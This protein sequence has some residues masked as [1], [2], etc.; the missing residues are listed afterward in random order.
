M[1][2][3][4]CAAL[5][6]WRRACRPR[7]RQ[8]LPRAAP[9]RGPRACTARRR[10]RRVRAVCEGGGAARGPARGGGGAPAARPPARALCAA[11]RS[12]AQRSAATPCLPRHTCTAPRLR[13]VQWRRA[14][15]SRGARSGERPDHPRKQARRLYAQSPHVTL[16]RA[17]TTP[18]LRCAKRPLRHARVAAQQPGA[19]RAARAAGACE[20]QRRGGQRRGHLPDA[21]HRPR[22]AAWRAVQGETGGGRYINRERRPCACARNCMISAGGG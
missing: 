20:A 2:A 10:C 17:L 9:Q 21:G 8:R 7:P 14:S 18:F 22:H 11:Q 3:A 5:L 13:H 4:A 6:P 12:A 1:A 19:A 15:R 16:T